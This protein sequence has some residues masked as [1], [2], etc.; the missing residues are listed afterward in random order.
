MSQLPDAAEAGAIDMAWCLPRL[1]PE[2]RAVWDAIASRYPSPLAAWLD[3]APA[4]QMSDVSP[5]QARR[6]GYVE[7][8]ELLWQEIK[9]LLVERRETL[10][11]NRLAKIERRAAAAVAALHTARQGKPKQSVPEQRAALVY[12]V[13]EAA[14]FPDWTAQQAIDAARA[15]HKDHRLLAIRARAEF[16]CWKAVR[17]LRTP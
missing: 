3:F 8:W 11:L 5:W 1:S 12:A 2:H 16:D 17:A 10:E 7:A 6:P 13:W 4:L 15:K 14:G 9:R